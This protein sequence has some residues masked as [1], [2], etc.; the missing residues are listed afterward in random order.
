MRAGPAE[1]GLT[2]EP[3]CLG[4]ERHNQKTLPAPTRPWTSGPGQPHDGPPPALGPLGS[5]VSGV[6]TT[7][8]NRQRDLEEAG[9]SSHPGVLPGPDGLRGRAGRT[10]GLALMPRRGAETCS[11]GWEGSQCRADNPTG[12]AATLWR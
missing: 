12:T 6:L 4:C 1:A 5:Q 2:S 7:L 10:H 3:L 8:V 11:P 9:F